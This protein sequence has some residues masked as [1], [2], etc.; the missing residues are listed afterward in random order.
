VV[1]CGSG[2]RELATGTVAEDQPSSEQGRPG[3]RIYAQCRVG[4][5]EAARRQIDAA[6]AR[7]KSAST[8]VSDLS[9]GR[10]G[11]APGGTRTHT[12]TL[13]RGLPLP[14]GY[15]GAAP[16]YGPAPARPPGGGGTQLQARQAARFSTD[17]GAAT[18]ENSAFG[19]LIWPSA[20]TSRPKNSAE[21][22][23]T[24]MRMRRFQV[25]MRLT[26]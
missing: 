24:R 16:A 6:G 9:R 14:L 21:V 13:L 11:G 23:S 17:T 18:R 5:E 12:G 10:A 19:S 7:V 26:W 1:R 20:T 4:Q 3:S 8:L 22:Q 25:G 15:G 2:T